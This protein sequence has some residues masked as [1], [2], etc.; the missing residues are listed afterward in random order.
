MALPTSGKRKTRKSSSLS[1]EYKRLKD[2]EEE[3]SS[4]EESAL[5]PKVSIESVL[6][7]MSAMDAEQGDQHKMDTN[8]NKIEN[9]EQMATDTAAHINSLRET[10]DTINLTV[11]GLQKEFSR[12][13]NLRI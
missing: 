4:H 12:V 9:L 10:V 6:P 11:V 2:V 7:E 3:L 13:E 5:K 1:P 8:L